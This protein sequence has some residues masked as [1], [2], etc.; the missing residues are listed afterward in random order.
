MYCA[1][2]KAND[3]PNPEVLRGDLSC[4]D[5]KIRVTPD[6]SGKNGTRSFKHRMHANISVPRLQKKHSRWKFCVG[7][8]GAVGRP[9][10]STRRLP[11][12]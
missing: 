9:V 7:I 5:F 1:I 3:Q 6:D 4:V 11:G 10:D 8:S 12:E 2:R